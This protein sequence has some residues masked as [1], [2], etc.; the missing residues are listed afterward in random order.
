MEAQQ[1]LAQP[2]RTAG[3]AS[4]DMRAQDEGSSREQHN[5]ND[6]PTTSIDAKDESVRVFYFSL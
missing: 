4:Q 5:D 6:A 1:Q 2:T 3:K